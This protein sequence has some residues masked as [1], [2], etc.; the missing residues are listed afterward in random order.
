MKRIGD[1]LRTIHV[2]SSANGNITVTKREEVRC[3]ICRDAGYLRSDVPVGHPLF[4]VLTPCDC[5]TTEERNRRFEKH[6]RLSN[7]EN[8]QGLT[9]DD[10]D[11]TVPGVDEA[12]EQALRYS[13]D[14]QG[15]I[16]FSGK[17]GTGKTHL[18]A[19]IAHSGLGQ[20]MQVL[21]SVVPDLLDHLRATFDPG[22]GTAYDETFTTIRESDLLVL[23][24]L[25]TENTTP[26]AREKLF[27]I[28]NHRYN[29]QLPTVITSNL[30]WRSGGIDE[31]VLSRILDQRRTCLVEIDAEDFRKGSLI[32][33]LRGN[34]S[35]RR[36]Q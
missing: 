20:G 4:G 19:A 10:F 6:R 14:M 27:Q 28:L 2:P 30:D 25:G 35:Y 3:S 17:V 33:K 32:P 13:R 36:G 29:D 22:S 8:L 7:L 23:D 11:H 5:K 18:A 15:W 12:Y 34:R 16:F 24:D 9:F 31:R 26:W 21:F 1:V